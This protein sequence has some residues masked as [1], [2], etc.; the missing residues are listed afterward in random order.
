MAQKK[1]SELTD[2]QK[3]GIGAG[4]AAAAA[5]AA[6]V[7]FLYGSKDAA[8]NRKR[9]KGWM[10]KAKG[11]VIEGLEKAGKITRDEYLALVEA[12][13]GVYGTAQRAS[14]SELKDF[15][16]EMESHWKTLQR[17]GVIKKIAGTVKKTPSRAKAV[18]KETK[19]ATKK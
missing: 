4:I 9:V 14:K 1:K 10:L 19:A 8:K 2:A 18:K 5:T 15:K 16:D 11:E 13:S 12:A 7:Y 6:G 3:V 17:S